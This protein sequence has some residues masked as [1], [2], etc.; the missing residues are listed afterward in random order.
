[1]KA[2]LSKIS[3]FGSARE[4][5]EGKEKSPL[6]QFVQSNLQALVE[7]I[8]KKGNTMDVR[9]SNNLLTSII[10]ANIVANT[11]GINADITADEYWKFLN[12]G[13]NGTLFSGAP[14]W[15]ALGYNSGSFADFV[16]SIEQ[17]IPFK[18][19]QPQGDDTIEETATGIAFAILKRGKRPRP[20]VTESVKE[21]KIFKDMAA[22]IGQLIGK[23]V[24]INIKYQ[25]KNGN[26]N[27]K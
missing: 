2:D 9:A 6:T 17:W 1:M 4:I 15:K 22:G 20:F 12:Y 11:N 24:A 14:N 3:S 26:N 18:N 16:K 10:P 19:I 25:L 8:K 7:E 23:S 21:T 27:N 5:L 13:V